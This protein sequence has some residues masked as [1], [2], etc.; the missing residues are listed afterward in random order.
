M[1]RLHY[2]VQNNGDGSASV[3]FQATEQDAEAGDEGQ[4][5][6]WGESSASSLRLDIQD[7][8]IVRWEMVYDSET[9]KYNGV[10]VPL[11]K[12]AG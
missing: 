4:S 3:K 6:G 7:G 8:V 10:W 5:E 9:K 1:F 2:Y 11:E 12:M